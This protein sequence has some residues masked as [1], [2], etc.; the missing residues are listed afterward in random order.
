M[1]IPEGVHPMAF[2]IQLYEPAFNEL[3]RDKSL[4]RVY[5]AYVCKQT[6]Q[7]VTHAAMV[8]TENLRAFWAQAR[9]LP[10]HLSGPVPP[11]TERR[12]DPKGAGAL[13]RRSRLG[14]F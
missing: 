2:D 9:A 13:H 10:V 12:E 3:A 14:L 11:P 8:G 6:W 1:R 7:F 4:R 5:R